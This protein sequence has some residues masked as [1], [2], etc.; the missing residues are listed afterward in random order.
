MAASPVVDPRLPN[1]DLIKVIAQQQLEA[2]A[3]MQY[4]TAK[5]TT[6][7]NVPNP[8]A[9]GLNV[10]ATISAF[11]DLA[12]ASA[13]LQSVADAAK[14]LGGVASSTTDKASI[15][16][17]AQEVIT[18]L[19]DWQIMV[20]NT[21]VSIEKLIAIGYG[22]PMR[23]VGEMTAELQGVMA[24]IASST[25]TLASVATAAGAARTTAKQ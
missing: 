21:F 5:A 13:A 3:A 25:S 24:A 19:G 9:F 2:N 22:T 8:A 16:A 17:Q 14:S 15:E 7:K 4:V 18:K 1:A 11:R 10:E 6:L 23:S 20:T 12:A